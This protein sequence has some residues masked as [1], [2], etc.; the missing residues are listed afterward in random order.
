MYR[1][2][3]RVCM[4]DSS[5]TGEVFRIIDDRRLVVLT[6]DGLEI[7]VAVSEIVPQSSAEDYSG[8]KTVNKDSKGSGAGRGHNGNIGKNGSVGNGSK[9][10]WSFVSLRSGGKDS[11]AGVPTRPSK[12]AAQNSLEIDLHA[13]KLLGG[14]RSSIPYDEVL[15][16][17]LSKVRDTLDRYG[18][19]H[20]SITF[21][22]GHGT[23]ALRAAITT[24][25]RTRYPRWTIED[26]PFHKYGYQGALTLRHK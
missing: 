7:E 3:D 24:L 1:C 8:K 23:G 18:S 26:A 19:S 25:I 16:L 15:E 2:G 6:E 9:T 13:E 14:T 17:Q 11:I 20:S 22:H 5:L 10:S 4:M 21:I 12:R